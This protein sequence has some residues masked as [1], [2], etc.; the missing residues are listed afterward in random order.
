MASPNEE[1][2]K[3]EDEYFSQRFDLE[4][5][6]LFSLQTLCTV[7]SFVGIFG[8]YGLAATNAF[9]FYPSNWGIEVGLGLTG[10]FGPGDN[11]SGCFATVKQ[12]CFPRRRKTSRSVWGFLLWCFGCYF[13]SARDLQYL[14]G[15]GH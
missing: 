5:T 4:L 8:I 14:P 7:L 6:R 11:D 3:I 1:L 9:H 15:A 2:Q 13:N 10:G 12:S